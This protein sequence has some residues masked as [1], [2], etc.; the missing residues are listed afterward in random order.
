MGVDAS[1]VA[2]VARWLAKDR[3]FGPVKIV[4]VGPRASLIALTA[5]AL[6]EKAISGVD[7]H[8][9]MRSLKE[10]LARNLTI[11]DTPE[12]FTF[13]L[14]ERFDIP[15]ISALISPRPVTEQ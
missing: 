4:S 15:Q 10:A 2:A 8:D 7:C 11:E 13:G 9:P 6:E 14:L 12:L 1:Q 3:G 5:A